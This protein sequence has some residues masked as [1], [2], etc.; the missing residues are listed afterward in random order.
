MLATG[1]EVCQPSQSRL[2]LCPILPAHPQPSWFSFCVP[3]P[4]VDSG[5]AQDRAAGQALNSSISR[6]PSDLASL[7][8]PVKS[9]RASHPVLFQ[10]EIS[11][12]AAASAGTPG[13][14]TRLVCLRR[15]F[16]GLQ[17]G[18]A[19]GSRAGRGLSASDGG[20]TGTD[21]IN[22]PN[23][24]YYIYICICLLYVYI[25]IYILYIYIY[26]IYIYIYVLL[27]MG[28]QFRTGGMPWLQRGRLLR[29]CWPTPRR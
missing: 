27:E 4:G 8:V 20:W 1:N 7:C 11:Y 14:I 13:R 19:L 15:L 25:Y 6:P 12:N 16:A 24:I 17:P 23:I 29:P 5:H 10:D 21:S 2:V 3:G 9:L 18:E 26:I 22:T 28:Q